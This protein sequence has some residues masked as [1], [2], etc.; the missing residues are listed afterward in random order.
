MK[1]EKIKVVIKMGESE[2]EFEGKYEEVWMS[3]NKYFSELYP[4]LQVVK[5]LVG[6]VDIEELVSKL[7][8]KVEVKEDRINILVG[9]DAKKKILLCLAGAYL[10]R[11][12]GIFEKEFLTPKEISDYTGIDEKQT[13]ARLS[14]LRKEG[15]VIRK[16]DGLYGFTPASM[17]ELIE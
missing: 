4:S 3:V 5:K 15:L 17:K 13:R 7:S 8:G 12:L 6:A 2:V 10:G 11:K 14:E 1:E 9:G 16:E